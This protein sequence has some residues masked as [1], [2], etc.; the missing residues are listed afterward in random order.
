MTLGEL[1][2]VI[3]N[4]TKEGPVTLKSVGMDACGDD[5]FANI[6]LKTP[7]VEYE[8]IMKTDDV[9]N[10]IQEI[11]EDFT[12]DYY[13]DTLVEGDYDEKILDEDYNAL[14]QCLE[15]IFDQL[16]NISNITEQKRESQWLSL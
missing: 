2:K 15:S 6:T 8:C 5:C 4:L 3:L 12:Y 9:Q 1:E 16:S 10:R 13:T 14:R 7:I 11:K